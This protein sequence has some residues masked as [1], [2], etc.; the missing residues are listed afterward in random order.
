MKNIYVF[1]RNTAQPPISDQPAD[2]ASPPFKDKSRSGVSSTLLSLKSKLGSRYSQ[3]KNLSISFKLKEEPQHSNGSSASTSSRSK[4]ASRA[5]RQPD[6]DGIQPLNPDNFPHSTNSTATLS[7]NPEKLKAEIKKVIAPLTQEGLVANAVKLYPAEPAE[8]AK[9]LAGQLGSSEKNKT[10]GTIV[11]EALHKARNNI[12]TETLVVINNSVELEPKNIRPLLAKQF[13]SRERLS[14]QYA[15][16][17]KKIFDEFM[18]LAQP[19][20]KYSSQHEGTI[21][22]S[23]TKKIP[24]FTRPDEV[25]CARRIALT[26]AITKMLK[27][28]DV[29]KPERQKKMI[30]LVKNN[31]IDLSK[32]KAVGR[33]SQKERMMEA[34]MA[35]E[36][37]ETEG[38]IQT[39]A[40]TLPALADARHP[41]KVSRL[42]KEVID[43]LVGLDDSMPLNKKESLMT[44][45]DAMG[46]ALLATYEE[47]LSTARSNSS[48]ESNS[49]LNKAVSRTP[50]TP[51]P[52]EL[53]GLSIAD[54]VELEVA[55]ETT[56]GNNLHVPFDNVPQQG[57]PAGTSQIPAR[58]SG[59]IPTGLKASASLVGFGGKT[60]VLLWP[61]ESRQELNMLNRSIKKLTEEGD[62]ASEFERSS[63]IDDLSIYYE[64]LNRAT[65]LSA[66]N[67]SKLHSARARV[68]ELHAQFDHFQVA[69]IASGYVEIA[70]KTVA[71]SKLRKL[72]LAEELAS[73]DQDSD[74][75]ED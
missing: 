50:L 30:D 59:S 60:S 44:T 24:A 71:G 6:G 39:F 64:D 73:L 57:N 18:L 2:L 68:N 31:F 10:T 20:N 43:I 47:A 55:G 9:Q 46:N 26:P 19:V 4:P 63:S 35:L 74:S 56:E 16:P 1:R 54:H 41:D 17:Q 7:C 8:M 45:V 34:V 72:S 40:L 61:K 58:L 48:N 52:E 33:S 32:D 5:T 66:S 25:E 12:L 3:H 42:Q 29:L 36:F 38:L 14:A 65:S 51:I 28:I 23:S 62:S 15:T 11:K 70:E 69:P 53:E 49:W 27:Q 22:K 75:D 37:H 13:A 67:L 21:N